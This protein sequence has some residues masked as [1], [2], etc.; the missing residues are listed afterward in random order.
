MAFLSE[1]IT[2][3]CDLLIFSFELRVVR[4]RFVMFDFRFSNRR[5][6]YFEKYR[7]GSA[8]AAAWLGIQVQNLIQDRPRSAELMSRRAALNGRAQWRALEECMLGGCLILA[9]S[10]ESTNFLRMGLHFCVVEMLRN[11]CQL[12]AKTRLIWLT[13]HQH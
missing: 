12:P 13:F 9:N 3:G 1:H 2:F 4:E 8:D 11:V 10:S 6:D 7:S 5:V